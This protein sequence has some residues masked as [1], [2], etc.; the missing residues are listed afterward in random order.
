MEHMEP[1]ELK[2]HI[3]GYIPDMISDFLYYDRKEDE[4]LPLN[5]IENAIKSGALSTKDIVDRFQK[6]LERGIKCE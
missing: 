6:E 4:E 1:D 3:L 2:D 5:M